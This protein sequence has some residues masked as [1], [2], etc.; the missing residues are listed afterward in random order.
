[1]HSHSHLKQGHPPYCLHT[2]TVCDS[3]HVHKNRWVTSSAHKD[4][5]LSHLS[6]CRYAMMFL[7][8]HSKVF[9]VYFSISYLLQP[10]S[11][12]QSSALLF[13]LNVCCNSTELVLVRRAARLLLPPLKEIFDFAH[14]TGIYFPYLKFTPNGSNDFFFHHPDLI[15]HSRV[16]YYFHIFSRLH[17]LAFFP[18]SL[19]FTLLITTAKLAYFLAFTLLEVTNDIITS[20]FI[21]KSMEQ[22]AFFFSLNNLSTND[23]PFYSINRPSC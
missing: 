22:K 3:H 16:V 9:N 7:K 8:L 12:L 19:P 21:A 15:S 18:V 4:D 1:M 5:S 20:Q 11:I 23:P 6:R 10:F 2:H 13:W 17:N 14:P